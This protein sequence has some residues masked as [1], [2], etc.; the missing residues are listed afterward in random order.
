MVATLAIV[1]MV[2]RGDGSSNIVEGDSLNTDIFENEKDKYKD[3]IKATK[4]LMNPPFALDEY[5]HLFIDR[6]LRDMAVGGLLFA[7]VPTTTLGGADN[8]RK[9]I[10]WREELIKRHSIRA[11][12]KMPEDLFIPV[13]KGTYAIILE[14][15]KP[16]ILDN[17]IVWAILKDGFIRSKTQQRKAQY[18][19][20]ELIL[21][22]VKDNLFG[23]KKKVYVSKEIDCQPLINKNDLTPEYHIGI[24]KNID[25][26]VKEVIKN[27]EVAKLKMKQHLETGEVVFKKQKKFSLA[28]FGIIIKGNSGRKKELKLGNLPLISTSE[29]N[30]GIS[31]FVDEGS[32]NKIY[33]NKI[34]I[35]ANGGSCYAN[36]HNYKFGANSDV[37]ILKLKEYYDSS[38]FA[39]FLCS[40]INSENWRFNY[41]RKF[42]RK[43]RY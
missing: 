24:N 33:E 9:E 1:N 8:S 17:D 41:Y 31:C 3:R 4:V 11:V 42:S 32:V 16:H 18:N 12:I 13:L 23:N 27:I 20:V 7:I 43:K 38:E 14:A 37:H 15:H 19:N 25:Y 10:T 35:S 36:Y 40:A 26:N 21:E 28:D 5:E 30:N 34:T 6:A 29:L 22:A 39:I 2:F